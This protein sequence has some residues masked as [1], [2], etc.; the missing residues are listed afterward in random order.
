LGRIDS[1]PRI[2]KNMK[3]IISEIIGRVQT[4]IKDQAEAVTAGSNI[5]S[6]DDYKQYVG[7]IEGLKLSLLIINEILTENDEDN[8]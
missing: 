4:E 2:S 1:V 8:S 5:N 6:F 7:K 3:D